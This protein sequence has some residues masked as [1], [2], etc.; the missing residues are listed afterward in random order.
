M[1]TDI[2]EA[3]KQL[4]ADPQPVYLELL[5]TDAWTLLTPIQIASKHPYAKD[6]PTLKKAVRVAKMI[7]TL[8]AGY[9]DI[10]LEVSDA[11]WKN[12]KSIFPVQVFL[13]EIKKLENQYI[14]LELTKY[15]VY[16]LVAAIQLAYRHPDY[17]DTALANYN[18]KIADQL[19]S[20]IPEG[21][22]QVLIESGWDSRF[23]KF[24]DKK[25]FGV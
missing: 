15:Q 23:D 5:K 19:K 25:G 11:G 24:S 10:L 2:V 17:K 21:V 9:S 13:S 12:K 20:A 14:T 16:C 4:M 8:I 6:S 1:D 22:L 3:F 18:K 7:Y